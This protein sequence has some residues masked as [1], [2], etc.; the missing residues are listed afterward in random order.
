MKVISFI[1]LSLFSYTTVA[2]QLNVKT[3]RPRAVCNNTKELIRLISPYIAINLKDCSQSLIEKGLMGTE[4]Y[5]VDIQ[6][7]LAPITCK[8]EMNFAIT[9][10][11]STNTYVHWNPPVKYTYL[12]EILNHLNLNSEVIVKNVAPNTPPQYKQVV[13]IPSC[14][15]H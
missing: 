14:V 13:Y 2:F 11:I 8:S 5:S 7:D 3:Q 1:L 9:F 10:P 15:L 12:D 4:T 6:I